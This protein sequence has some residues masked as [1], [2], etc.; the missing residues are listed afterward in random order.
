MALLLPAAGCQSSRPKPVFAPVTPPLVW[1]PPPDRPRIRYIGAL[2]GEESLGIEAHGWDKVREVLIGPDPLM[3]FS[4]PTAVAVAGDIVF[5]ADAG[6]GIVHRLDLAGRTY[7]ILRGNPADPLQAPLDLLIRENELVI[8]DRGRAVLDFL[9][10]D[11]TWLRTQRWPELTAPVALAWQ[12]PARL[13]W[14]VDAELH[15][16]VAVDPRGDLAARLGQRGDGPGYFNYPSAACWHP[17]TGLV[18][19]DAMNFRVQAFAEPAAGV[20]DV[21]FGQ[22]GD[23]AGDFSRPRGVAVDSAGHIYVTDNQFENVQIFDG[24]GRLLLA[25]GREGAGPGEF[26]LPAGITIDAQDRIWIADSFN[27]RVQVF[28][29]LAEERS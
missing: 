20:P 11:G 29:Y 9:R 15:A 24:Q 14:I 1:P 4:R 5:V 8:V 13:L 16:C 18:V 3:A 27:R 22:K 19:A 23:A 6:L 26:S 17:Q 2:Y 21:V 10:L 7:A 12:A 28:Q 25:F